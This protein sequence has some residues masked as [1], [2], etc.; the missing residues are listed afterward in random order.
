MGGIAISGAHGCLTSGVSWS[1]RRRGLGR[2]DVLQLSESGVRLRQ[3][4]RSHERLTGEE[5]RTGG[6]MGF[7]GSNIVS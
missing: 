4:C 2:Y 6:G 7:G 5:G 1:W 3:A